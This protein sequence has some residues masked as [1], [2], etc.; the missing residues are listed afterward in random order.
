MTQDLFARV[1]EQNIGLIKKQSRLTNAKIILT[2]LI[3]GLGTMSICPQFGFDPFKVGEALPHYFMSYGHW[4]CGLMCG[5]IFYGAGSVLGLVILSKR[6]LFYY[7]RHQ[8]IKSLSIVSFF[9]L[10]LMIVANINA[11]DL[12]HYGLEFSMFWI[13]GALAVQGLANL[14][15]KPRLVLN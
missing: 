14:A 1:K 12:I 11:V 6:D 15:A 4:A 9:Y 2:H 5:S 3:A 13:I 10:L 8:F 7:S